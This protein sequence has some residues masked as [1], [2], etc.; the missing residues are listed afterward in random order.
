MLT[1]NGIGEKRGDIT[2]KSDFIK[3]CDLSAT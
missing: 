1:I 2:F 3:I